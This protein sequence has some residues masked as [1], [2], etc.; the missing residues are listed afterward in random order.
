VPALIAHPLSVSSDLGLPPAAVALGAAVLAAAVV[1]LVRVR[2][3]PDEPVA[4]IP[5]PWPGP[6]PRGVLATRLLGVLALVGLVYVGRFG[7]GLELDNLASPVA[8]GLFWPLLLLASLVAGVRLWRA[9]DPL[10]SLV[11][12]GERLVGAPTTEDDAPL[13]VWPAVVGAVAWTTYLHGY[14]RTTPREAAYAVA[15]Y[16]VVLVAGGIALGR[17]WLASADVFS[18]LARWCGLRSRL[19]EWPAPAGADAVTGALVGGV[20][21]G[22]LRMSPFWIGLDVPARLRSPMTGTSVTA[23]VLAAA[24]G[25]LPAVGAGRWAT[26]RGAPGSVAAVLV[27]VVAA[28]AVSTMLRRLLICLQLVWIELSDP[29]GRG[30]DLFGTGDTVVD[31]N[32]FGTITQRWTGVALITAAGLLSAYILARRVPRA[33]SQDPAALTLYVVVALGVLGAATTF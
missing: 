3:E 11:R 24:L 28:L 27:P 20:L 23:A 18:L 6:L 4:A 5:D 29:L 26:R 31:P 9:L 14:A 12:A 21:F 32:P 30:S 10:D 22:D 16:A 19:A 2:R 13:P 8:T 7:P 25:A 1:N 33:R 17:R 15:G